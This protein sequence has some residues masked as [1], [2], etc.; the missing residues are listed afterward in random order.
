MYNSSNSNSRIKSKDQYQT[1]DKPNVEMEVNRLFN[2][3][4]FKKV[5]I[6]AGADID[7]PAFADAMGKEMAQGKL[8]NSKI[9]NVYGEMK[10]I[11]MGEFDKLKSS[12]YLL[13]P[14]MAYAVGR[15]KNGRGLQLF[16]CIFDE[17][18]PLVTDQKTY[19]NF[20]NLMEAILAYHKFYGGE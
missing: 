10:R 1:T 8:T 5:W 4:N 9:R 6:V 18:F 12:F 20:C 13:K 17:C 2:Q 11:Q 14:K 15:E 19:N 16:K 7:M 3:A